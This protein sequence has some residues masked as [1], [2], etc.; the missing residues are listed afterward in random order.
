MKKNIQFLFKP[1]PKLKHLVEKEINQLKSYGLNIIKI[2][3]FLKK[4][5]RKN[6]EKTDQ[7][8]LEVSIPRHTIIATKISDK[9]EKAITETFEVA[10]RQIRK[11]ESRRRTIQMR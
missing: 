9:F 1:S 3:L 10:K 4:A 11:I 6:G 2:E 5:T 8:A 7:V